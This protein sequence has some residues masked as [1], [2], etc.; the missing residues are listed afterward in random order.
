MSFQGFADADA[1]FFRLLAKNQDRAWFQAH[2]AEFEAGWQAP[3]K[4]LLAEV[5]AGVDPA[6]KHSELDAPKIF[7]IFRDVRFSKDKSPYKTHIGGVIPIR[8]QGKM[9]EV[10]MALYFHV[11][12]PSS[13]A[14]AGHYMMDSAQLLKF[15]AAVADAKRGRELDKLLAALAK[16]GFA[17]HSYQNYQ[18]VPK[19]YDPEHPRA[20]HL[21]RKG[22]TVSFPPL[23]KGA[24][25][26]KKLVPWLVTHAKAAAPLVEW[27]VFA[28]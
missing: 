24:L 6:F 15:R 18:R 11:G 3:M 23:P 7:R 12:Q 13:F 21:K 16:K 26:S 28:T 25:A 22:L 1:K 2:K 20:E 5:H 17:A 19:G 4:E 14:A 8:R 27:L 10:P 9:T